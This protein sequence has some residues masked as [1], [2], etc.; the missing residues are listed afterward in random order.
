VLEVGPGSGYFSVELARRVRHGR[1]ELLDLQPEMLAKARRKLELKRIWNVGYTADDASVGIPFADETFDIVV[2]VSVL[3]EIPDAT[4]CLRQLFCALRPGGI[5]AV[6]EHV[7]DPDW[8]KFS[9]LRPLVELQGF[10]LR[11]RW[12]RWWNYTAI[13]DRPLPNPGAV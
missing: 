4:S 2:M 6:H 13:F 1:L 7:P 5:L 3:G 8:I 9:V 10:S 11:K 12:G